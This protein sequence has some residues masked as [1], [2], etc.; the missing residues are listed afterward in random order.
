MKRKM[1]GVTAIIVI[2]V[3]LLFWSGYHASTPTVSG[4]KVTDSRGHQVVIPDHPQHFADLW[5]PIDE[6]MVMLGASDKIT[7]TVGNKSL[8]PWLFHMA[9]NLEKAIAIKGLVPNVETLKAAHIDIAITS[10][11]SPAT[12]I[13]ERSGIPVIEAGFTDT[14]SFQKSISLL[15][16]MVN[17]DD[18]RKAAQDYTNQLQQV[19]ASVRSKINSLAVTDR[20]RV[21]HIQ[22]LSP[23]QVDGD[24]SII[25]EWIT[26][27][28][29]RNA[30]E[31]ITGNKKI[32]SSEQL[33]QW[34]PDIIILG[35]SCRDL[36][37]KDGSPLSSVWY[38]LRAVKEGRVYRNPAG[39]FAWDRYGL[40]YPLQL[41]W[42]AQLFHPALFPSL[43]IRQETTD[44]YKRY[45]HY[46]PSHEEV[47]AILAA[48][49]PKDA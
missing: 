12:P 8:L 1:F 46:T 30:A 44:F 7:V 29:G 15:A 4:R 11:N 23:L 6:V 37:K 10:S 19:V 18:A 9:P 48:L 49:P 42:A 38:D 40:E 16:E 5:Y 45:L 21:L 36:P 3:A 47:E 17:T 34:N 43:D 13:V 41:Q 28:G 26:V 22:S 33:A 27:A 20:P 31:A 14:A 25:N 2:V 39:A 32:I 24:K 35:R